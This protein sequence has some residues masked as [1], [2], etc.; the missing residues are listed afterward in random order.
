[1]KTQLLCGVCHTTI[2]GEV[3]ADAVKEARSRGWV[4]HASGR[5]IDGERVG[6]TWVCTDC[7]ITED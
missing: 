2:K 3:H 6:R 7:Q 4:L 5:V 1:M